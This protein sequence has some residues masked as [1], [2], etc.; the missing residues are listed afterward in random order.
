M[1]EGVVKIL[2]T[3]AIVN[4]IHIVVIVKEVFMLA[5]F[6]YSQ[7]SWLGSIYIISHQPSFYTPL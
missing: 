6:E 5:S 3:Y 7:A 1:V 4:V 2:E